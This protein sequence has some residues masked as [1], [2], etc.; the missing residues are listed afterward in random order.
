MTDMLE[1]LVTNHHWFGPGLNLPHTACDCF[2]HLGIPAVCPLGLG[3]CPFQL[4]VPHGQG[5]IQP[6]NDNTVG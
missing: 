2:T 3:L 4:E 1:R 6:A 5:A